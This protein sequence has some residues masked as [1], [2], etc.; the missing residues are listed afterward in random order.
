MPSAGSL[1]S[2]RVATGLAD[3]KLCEVALR[4]SRL[5]AHHIVVLHELTR[6]FVGLI[7]LT[8]VVSRTNA[9][10]HILAD[11]VAEASPVTVKLNEPAQNVAHLFEKHGLGEVAVFTDS[12][13]YVG[14]IT[15]ESV[16]QWSR[17]QWRD[18]ESRLR[19]GEQ[20]PVEPTGTRPGETGTGTVN[21]P[22][23]A[24]RETTTLR[25]DGPTVEKSGFPYPVDGAPI[26]ILLVEDHE[27]SRV[28]LKTILVRRNF[29]VVEAQSL[30][31]AR[32]LLETRQ[33]DLLISDIGLPD[34]SGY[35]LMSLLRE[36]TGLVGIS[37][38]AEGR[39]TDVTMSKAAGFSHHFTKPL[40]IPVLVKTILKVVAAKPGKSSE[41]A[42]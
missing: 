5:N 35:E 9:G 40:D 4:V 41:P 27:P 20:T 31:E 1:I 29:M 23:T 8:E 25:I 13:Q 38:T 33:F 22:A 32:T 7:R 30:Q 42:Q 16:L 18:A 19:S 2:V 6:K 17:Q 21:F 37:V 24:R 14:L 10:N 26:R 39:D 15:T 34:G 11:L 28:A 3:E 36:R 12:L